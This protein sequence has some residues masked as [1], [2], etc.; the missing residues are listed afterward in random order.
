MI[1]VMLFAQ[2][3]IPKEHFDS[4][5][6][7]ALASIPQDTIP[8]WRFL[9]MI[10]A[11][12]EPLT[13]I[14]QAKLSYLDLKVR[15][16]R[17]HNNLTQAMQPFSSSSL[18]NN[19]DSLEFLAERYLE[20]SMPD[21]ALSLLMKA[22]EILPQNSVEADHAKLGICEAYRQKQ[23]YN[24]GI[25]LI[26][27]LLERPSPLTLKNLAYAYSRLAALYN[28]WEK[29]PAS[30]TDS[31]FKYSLLS[32]DVAT[33]AGDTASLALSLNELSFQYQRK[34]NYNKALDLSKRSVSDF[35]LAGM[36]F[37]AMN[38]LI[39]QS[40]I[41]LAKKEYRASLLALEEAGSLAPLWENRNL[42]MRIYQQYATIYS[43][44][45]N[46]RVAYEFHSLY[47]HLLVEF[48]KDRINSQINEQSA[49]YDLLLKEQKITEELKKNEFKRRQIIFLAIISITLTLAFVFSM[50]YF[51]LKRKGT[52]RQKLAEAVLETE[53]NE[54][55]RI[56]RD[57]HDGLGP[58]LSAIN[59]YFQAFL[60]SKPE[61][62]EEIKN[63]LQ[64]VISEA[65]DE[66]SRISHNIS[67]HV[68][69]K[70]GL[71]TALNNLIAPLTANGRYE[72]SFNCGCQDKLDPKVELT[73]YRCITE[74]LNNTMKH[75]EASSISLDIRL[76][77]NNLLIA[78]SDNGKG[79]NPSLARKNGMGLHNI[80][81]R[82]ESSGGSV[83]LS[84]SSVRGA[85]VNISIP[86]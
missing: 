36:S 6:D 50:F 18:P 46:F 60:D 54:R 42:Y 82:V 47:N 57:L 58:V 32:G 1:P 30:Y 84:G 70:H 13:D 68:L 44:T 59:H 66:V 61:A 55:R 8:A 19:P 85:S 15:E 35:L 62:R 7:R 22:L 9:R 53:T 86:L 43:Q 39:N 20:R 25:D 67:P 26:S 41:Y 80:T 65:I 56:A 33:K 28:E 10:S 71:V 11:D 38:A 49:R 72:I 74:L 69:E 79:F 78:Y 23:E 29:P 83:V 2:N 17:P 48:F 45:G 77:G 75:A 34:G 52:L 51:R 37:H 5:C 73:V 3:R 12:K 40:N 81:N 16:K 4:L 21:R 31:V 64:T 14:Q 76:Q 24:K 63:R 27:S